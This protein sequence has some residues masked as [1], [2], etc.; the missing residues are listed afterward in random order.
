MKT[1]VEQIGGIAGWGGNKIT[2]CIN[3]G[4]IKSVTIEQDVNK[5][6]IG[7]IVGGIGLIDINKCYNKGNVYRQCCKYWRDCWCRD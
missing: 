5:K 2:K 1:E 7:G 6:L 3:Y 4:E